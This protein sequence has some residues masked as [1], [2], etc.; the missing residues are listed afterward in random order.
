MVNTVLSEMSHS[1]ARRLK[2]AENPDSVSASSVHS[3]SWPGSLLSAVFV[4][5]LHTSFTLFCCRLF[6]I[7]SPWRFFQFQIL[8]FSSCTTNTVKSY[9]YPLLQSP[10]SPGGKGFPFSVLQGILFAC[11]RSMFLHPNCAVCSL[12]D[13]FCVREYINVYWV[14]H[15]KSHVPFRAL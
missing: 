5:P 1:D 11:L 13:W 15:S 2:Q 9:K 4:I 3:A 14:I 12:I 8:H 7:L 6:F 10:P